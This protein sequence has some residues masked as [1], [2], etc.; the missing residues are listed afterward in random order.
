MKWLRQAITGSDNRTIDPSFLIVVFTVFGILPLVI[1]ILSSLSALDVWL[2]HHEAAVGALGGGIAAVIAAVG[3]LIASCATILYQD[4]KPTTT[5][6][7]ATTESTTVKTVAAAPAPIPTDA[8]LAA[9]RGVEPMPAQ[10][11]AKDVGKHT[12][13]V[14]KRKG[15]R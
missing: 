11:S 4:R 5:T 7:T 14:P 12:A 8:L 1:L 9:G 6:T 13:L 2:N 3:A 15:K 10:I